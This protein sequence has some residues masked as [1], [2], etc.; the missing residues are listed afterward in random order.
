MEVTDN[1]PHGKFAYPVV[2]Y[3]C[4]QITAELSSH[5]SESGF[6]RRRFRI[7]GFIGM[8]IHFLAVSIAHDFIV[9]CTPGIM[10]L[11]VLFLLDQDGELIQNLPLYSRHSKQIS[12]FC[13]TI[14]AICGHAG[15]HGPGL[16]CLL[17]IFS[18]YSNILST[19]WGKKTRYIW[20]INCWNIAILDYI[21]T[22]TMNIILY[23]LRNA[24]FR[25]LHPNYFISSQHSYK[26]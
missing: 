17:I 12:S 25:E 26:S 8:P 3:I 15:Y 23:F 21:E 10:E 22:K 24:H 19:G 4:L 7:S 13:D 14:R 20:S 16:G 2:R 1:Y 5:E 11:S 9:W 6:K 18:G